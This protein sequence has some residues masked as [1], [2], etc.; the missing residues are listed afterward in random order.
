[1]IVVFGSINIDLM[2]QVK[3]FPAPGETVL[4]PAYEWMPGGKGMNQAIAAAR[5]G[6]KVAMV[7]CVG[8]DGFGTRALNTM[9][10]EGVLS[11]GVVVS[12]VLPTGCS[13]I[14]VDS[15]GENL[16]VMSRGA[17]GQASDSQIPDEILGPQNVL[18]LQMELHDDVNWSVLKRASEKG[19]KTILNLAPAHSLPRDV[20][21]YLDYLILNRIEAEQIAEK[22]GLKIEKDALLLARSLAKNCSLTCVITLSGLGS[23]AVC[24]DTGFIVPA[25]DMEDVVDTT[26]AGDTFCGVFAAAIHQKLSLVDALRR[27]SV[28]GSLSVSGKGAQTAMP[29]IDDIVEALPRLPDAQ[30]ISFS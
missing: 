28:A 27:A 13:T 24:G 1:M 6:V 25:L 9:R 7:G 22:L 21:D 17:N 2:M 19:A 26:G 23:V 8:D 30:Q 14:F 3:R 16:V 15:S 11:S 5:A 4:T 10:R 20:L 18:L 29:Y 12:D